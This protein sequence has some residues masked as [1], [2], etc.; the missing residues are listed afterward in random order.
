MKQ[1]RLLTRRTVGSGENTYV[2]I[3]FCC[4]TCNQAYGIP[5]ITVPPQ[6][7]RNQSVC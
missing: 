5:E 4:P 1:L 7:E 2:V 3:V 6:P